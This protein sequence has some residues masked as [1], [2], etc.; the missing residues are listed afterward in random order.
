MSTLAGSN[1][2]TWAGAIFVVSV[3]AVLY[4]LTAARDILVGQSPELITAAATLGVA[5]EPDYPLFMMLGHLFSCLS[6]GS[7]P[8][9]VNLLSVICQGA[10]GRRYLP[11]S[12]STDPIAF[13]CADCGAVARRQSDILVVVARRRS[14]SFE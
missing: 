6:V 14:F 4:F 13:G 12:E 2:K 7:I 11:H 1:S 9:R 10:T 3:A 5:H 8:F